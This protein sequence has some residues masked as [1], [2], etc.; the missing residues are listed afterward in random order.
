M[1]LSSSRHFSLCPDSSGLFDPGGICNLTLT[2]ADAFLYASLLTSTAQTVSSPTH[3]HDFL[4]AESLW[5]VRTPTAYIVPCLRLVHLVQRLVPC[6]G[7]GSRSCGSC[8]SIAPILPMS[9]GT[10]VLLAPKTRYRWVVNP[11]RIKT[12]GLSVPFH[13]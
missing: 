3:I 7:Q 5:G 4:G 9:H 2:T 8:P 11:F 13:W 12:S 10:S 6:D 1:G